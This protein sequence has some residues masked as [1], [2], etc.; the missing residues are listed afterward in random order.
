MKFLSSIA[1]WIGAATLAFAA[2]G[3]Q[4]SYIQTVIDFD[5]GLDTS[6]LLF[7]PLLAHEDLLRQDRYA[8]QP[9][10]LD[11]A[12]GPGNLVGTL[13]EKQP[14]GDACF[15]IL[16]PRS[17]SRYL[18]ALNGS[19]VALFRDDFSVFRLE[20][21]DAAFVANIP[22][23][24]PSIPLLVRT[25]GFL[26]GSL[27]YRFD[28]TT[29]GLVG[30]NLDFATIIT[31]QPLTHLMVDQVFFLGLAC[32]VTGSCQ[33]NQS[34]AQFALD[35]ITVSVPEPQ[36][37]ALIALGLLAAAGSARRARNSHQTPAPAHA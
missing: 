19:A 22:S 7:D 31:P 13:V 32:D 21:F 20:R 37:W 5:Q 36:T 1:G 27:A 25:L 4:A 3:A 28:A 12:A 34:T 6:A 8:L 15:G 24:V 11:E 26:G 9:F 16:C 29:S 18:A 2:T 17:N 33:G 10:S 30:G 35:N 14:P 23:T